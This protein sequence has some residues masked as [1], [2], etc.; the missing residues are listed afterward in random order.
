MQE[1]NGQI[2]LVTGAGR[3]IGSAIAKSLAKEGATVI[4]NYAGNAQAAQDT[5]DSIL[6]DGGSAEKYQCDVSDFAAVEEMIKYVVQKYEKIDILV[7]NAGITKD[8]LLMRMKEEDFDKVINVNL[9]GTY[10][11]TKNVIPYMM[12]QK[13]GKIINISSVVG[14][15]GNAGQANY[16][17]SKAG[18]IGFTK[19][20]AKELASRNILANCV[21]PG[22]IKTDMT[23]VLSDSVKE[24]IN[25]QIPLKKMGTAEEVA[26][27]VYFLGNEENTYITGQVLNVDGGMLM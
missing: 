25:S 27:A 2:A 13:Y 18:I 11:V 6:K 16:A 12:K 10:N 22:F 7:N 3:G 1:M 17:A 23:D 4:V 24:S 19:S 5:V 15:S 14:V 8:T 9:K 20:V 26:N 21:A